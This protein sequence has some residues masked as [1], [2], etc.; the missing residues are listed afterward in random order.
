MSKNTLIYY[1]HNFS[2]RNQIQHLIWLCL[3]VQ[4]MTKGQHRPKASKE[5]KKTAKQ[6]F[7]CWSPRANSASF[8][9]G[10]ATLPQHVYLLSINSQASWL[11][12]KV[13]TWVC[14]SRGGRNSRAKHIT[15]P[16]GGTSQAHILLH[17]SAQLNISKTCWCKKQQEQQYLSFDRTS[18][19]GESKFLTNGRHS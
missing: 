11:C 2:R 18:L 13:R 1:W 10:S 12:G 9:Q 14:T 17:T 8:G 6:H 4:G 5:K 19:Q 16:T 15:A 7:F 3:A